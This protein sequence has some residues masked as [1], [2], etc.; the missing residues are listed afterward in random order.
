M[1]ADLKDT[2]HE[3]CG[4]GAAFGLILAGFAVVAWEPSYAAGL[5]ALAAIFGVACRLLRDKSPDAKKIDVTGYK[6]IV[7]WIACAAALL[8][9]LAMATAQ[10][11]QAFSLSGV[12]A[13]LFCTWAALRRYELGWFIDARGER[14]KV[15]ARDRHGVLVNPTTHDQRRG[16]ELAEK[17]GRRAGLT[18][19]GAGAVLCAAAAWGLWPSYAGF[20]FLLICAGALMAPG[21]FYFLALELLY[22]SGFQH[23]KGAKVLD[24]PPRPPGL[25]SVMAQKAHGDARLATPDEALELLNRKG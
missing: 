7:L 6:A 14:Q 2:L 11:D 22:Q 19:C 16:E 24:P 4:L 5:L 21:F 18:L 17:E 8:G 13:V 1:F 20:S 3:C 15:V 10:F 9:I 12:S 23:M 25:D